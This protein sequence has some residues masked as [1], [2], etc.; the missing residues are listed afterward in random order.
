MKHPYHLLS[1]NWLKLSWRAGI[2]I[3][4]INPIC[5]MKIKDSQGDISIF[6]VG[7][8]KVVILLRGHFT[9]LKSLGKSID[10][11]G[12]IGITICC[13]T[14]LKRV[15]K[16]VE[17]AKAHTKYINLCLILSSLF[18]SSISVL[19]QSQMPHGHISSRVSSSLGVYLEISK[20][21]K[22]IDSIINQVITYSEALIVALCVFR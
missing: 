15:A 5:S 9:F 14:L 11:L 12:V 6:I 18:L 21:C 19:H 13:D 8:A 1:A 4:R 7:T 20:C 2:S 3:S 10:G 17:R 16:E 22:R